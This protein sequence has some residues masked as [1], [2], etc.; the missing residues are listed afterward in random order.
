MAN[1]TAD[2]LNLLKQTKAD[3]KTA[4][5]NKGQTVDDTTPFSDYAEKIND[6]DTSNNISS[7]FDSNYDT[8]EVMY[9]FNYGIT[10]SLR[11][12]RNSYEFERI[13]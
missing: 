12:L 5:V 6:I 7:Y 3:I 8:E 1:T 9:D 11:W 4:L 10:R 13:S 2:K